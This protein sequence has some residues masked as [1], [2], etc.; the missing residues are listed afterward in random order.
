MRIS[1]LCSHLVHFLLST[2]RMFRGDLIK[3]N[4]FQPTECVQGAMLITNGVLYENV[5]RARLE[6]RCFSSSRLD[7]IV[8]P[9]AY[10]DLL[11]EYAAHV[12]CM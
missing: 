7:V 1:A 2:F 9:L 3:E 8:F 10:V 12:R 5:H 4:L 6:T 11:F